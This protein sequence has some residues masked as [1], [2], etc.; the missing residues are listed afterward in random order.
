MCEILLFFFFKAKVVCMASS[1]RRTIKVGV[2]VSTGREKKKSKMERGEA[3]AVMGS[4]Q[5]SFPLSEINVE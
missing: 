1:D 4:Y 3:V 5:A 2:G